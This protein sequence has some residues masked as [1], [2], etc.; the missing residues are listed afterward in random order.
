MRGI[1]RVKKHLLWIALKTWKLGYTS[2]LSVH[3]AHPNSLRRC[4]VSHCECGSSLQ[5]GIWSNTHG[6]GADQ[7]EVPAGVTTNSPWAKHC[8]CCMHP[9]QQGREFKPSFFLWH[10]WDGDGAGLGVWDAGAK[11]KVQFGYVQRSQGLGVKL[12]SPLHLATCWVNQE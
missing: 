11:L 8:G 5:S 1:F 4:V 9:C 12:C 3:V 7:G 2:T 10:R 6:R